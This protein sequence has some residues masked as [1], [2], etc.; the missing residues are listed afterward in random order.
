[1]SLRDILPEFRLNDVESMGAKSFR[2]LALDTHPKGRDV[3]SVLRAWYS[4]CMG[5]LP[6]AKNLPDRIRS[7]D[8]SRVLCSFTVWIA[9][10]LSPVLFRSSL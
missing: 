2:G 6:E 3:N 10:P 7:P 9:S 1:M 8:F 4:G 5:S